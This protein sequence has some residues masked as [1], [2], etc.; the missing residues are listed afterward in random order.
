MSRRTIVAAI[1]VILG[2]WVS[3]WIGSAVEPIPV[4]PKPL[5]D[6]EFPGKIYHRGDGPLA[7]SRASAACRYW[8]H[9]ADLVGVDVARYWPGKG[10]LIEGADQNVLIENTVYDVANWSTNGNLTPTDDTDINLYDGHSFK[11]VELAGVGQLYQTVTVTAEDY[12]VS[13]LAYT[14]G[15]AVTTADIDAFADTAFTNEIGTTYYESL[16]GGVYL[17]WGEFTATAADWHVGIEVKANKTVYISLLTCHKSAPT[18]EGFSGPRSL[19]PS[20]AAPTT[21]APEVVTIPADGNIGLSEGTIDVMWT[22][23]CSEA[24]ANLNFIL[25]IYKD[26][27]NEIYVYVFNSKTYFRHNVAG[28]ILDSNGVIGFSRN[29]FV[30]IRC[31][32]GS[33]IEGTKDTILYASVNNGAWSEIASAATPLGGTFPT[34]ATINLGR[35]GSAIGYVSSFI[36][37]VTIWKEAKVGIPTH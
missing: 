23:G 20:G 35:R 10:L 1:F 18:N 7:I 16:G 31:C 15:S 36:R 37:R 4:G 32:Y 28:N 25:S 17:C 9:P 5:L 13:F 27:S 30:K 14:D 21:R 24:S 19:I 6:I 3:L 8:E 34:G 11:L 33:N 12:I 22:A 2:V 26:A 29:D